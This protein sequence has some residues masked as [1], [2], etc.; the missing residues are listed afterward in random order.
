MSG[1]WPP[2][3]PCPACA[4]QRVACSEHLKDPSHHHITSKSPLCLWL[5][6]GLSTHEALLTYIGNGSQTGTGCPA[7]CKE[8]YSK[9]Q[10]VGLQATRQSG[11]PACQEGSVPPTSCRSST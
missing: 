8:R 5:R 7:V 11:K 10:E 2:S 4:A 1:H 3:Q 9:Q 6:T